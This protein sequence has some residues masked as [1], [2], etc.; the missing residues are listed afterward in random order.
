[1]KIE[2]TGLLYRLALWGVFFES[3]KIDYHSK[4]VCTFT[5][6]KQSRHLGL[7]VGVGLDTAHDVVHSGS[8]R[9]RLFCKVYAEELD[10]DLLQMVQT[11]LVFH[12]NKSQKQ[13][14]SR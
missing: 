9:N 11:M 7:T 5:S 13:L 8:D 14:I 10:C 6:G 2:R 3:Y 4:D 1:M 12:S